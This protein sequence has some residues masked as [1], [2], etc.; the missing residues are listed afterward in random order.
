MQ[1]LSFLVRK[2]KVLKMCFPTATPSDFPESQ[3]NLT[4]TE[5]K[6]SYFLQLYLVTFPVFPGLLKIVK[7]KPHTRIDLLNLESCHDSV[8]DFWFQDRTCLD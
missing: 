2:V 6:E 5:F 8:S 4:C 3:E 7:K 1:T